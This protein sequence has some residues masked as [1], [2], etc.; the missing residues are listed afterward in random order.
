M[1]N[2]RKRYTEEVPKSAEYLRQA[3]PLMSQQKAA[4]HPVSYA[5][6]YEVVAGINPRL[7]AAVEERIK[8]GQRLDEES[9]NALFQQFIA[10]INEEEAER[11][12]ANFE[13]IMS[14]MATSATQAG[15]QANEFSARLESW[16]DGL[17][18]RDGVTQ[19][20]QEIAA[21]LDETRDMQSAVNQ[22]QE[23]LLASHKEIESLKK[24]VTRAREEAVSDA[25][26]GLVNRKG[27]DE[28]LAL[29]LEQVAETSL[30]PSLIVADIDHFKNINDTYGHLFGDK[31]LRAV[32]HIIK[33]NV[34]GKDTAARYGGEEFLILLP[35]TSAQ[36]AAKVAETIRVAVENS[37]I[38]N[39]E[40]GDVAGKITIS[41]GIASL[42]AGDTSTT[43]VERADK[44][45]YQSKNNGRNKVS[46]AT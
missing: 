32:A 33:Q 23:R 5:V 11:I 36:G 3:L 7:T 6:W 17:H 30:Q 37:R 44:A 31:V 29:C 25:L 10:E 24:E 13:R 12:S 41:F 21:L 8:Q 14:D 42:R 2:R 4:L 19:L 45:L 40:K 26:T 28:E 16:G 27:F 35:N 1:S 15:S 9:T 22:L 38:K 20:S 34:K 46:I 39:T 18:K 43:F